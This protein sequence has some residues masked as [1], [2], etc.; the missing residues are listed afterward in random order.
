MKVIL[1]IAGGILLAMVVMGVVYHVYTT[2]S[3]AEVDAEWQRIRL[4]SCEQVGDAARKEAIA[5]GDVG[6][7]R[8]ERKA[9]FKT[10]QSLDN[11]YH[12]AVRDCLE[13]HSE[14]R[15]EHHC[16]IG[17]VPDDKGNCWAATPKQ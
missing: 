12:K 7:A 14:E 11:V 15:T 4:E 17:T 13:P 1:Q 6:D 8:G 5:A 16:A 2:P 9:A 10:R 3:K